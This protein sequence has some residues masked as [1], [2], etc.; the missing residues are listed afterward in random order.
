MLTKEH[1]LEA[2]EAAEVFPPHSAHKWSVIVSGTEYDYL[3]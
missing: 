2:A 1:L 3:H